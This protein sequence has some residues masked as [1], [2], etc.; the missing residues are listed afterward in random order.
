MDFGQAG[1]YVG[2][3]LSGVTKKQ[4]R[5]GKCLA[6][7][8]SIGVRRNFEA[9]MYFLKSDEGG[10]VT[11]ITTGYRPQS[12]LATSDVEVRF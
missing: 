8:G 9:E 10:R 1:D 3:L 11:G 12:Y 7:Q 4:V 2:F 6:L 5:R